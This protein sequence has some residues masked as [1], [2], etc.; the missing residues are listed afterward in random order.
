[1]YAY[2][3]ILKHLVNE[4]KFSFLI[5]YKNFDNCLWHYGRGFDELLNELEGLG[6]KAES[7][8]AFETQMA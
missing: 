2:V 7:L 4:I 5:N 6:S 8:D 1:M 3:Q